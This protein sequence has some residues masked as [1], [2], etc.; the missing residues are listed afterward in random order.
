PHQPTPLTATPP[1]S[2]PL[3][4]PPRTPDAG[5][6]PGATLPPTAAGTCTVVASQSGDAQYA[7]AR[8]IPGSF[9]VERIPQ[10]IS[11]SPPGSGTVDQP[12][13]L[14]GKASSR[15]PVTYASDSMDVCTVAGS[16][17]TPASAGTCPV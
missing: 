15:L 7:P 13:I 5:N 16:T 17:L 12:V 8:P 2:R 6:V 4:P 1:P 14:T 11:F 3:P 10:T 9:P